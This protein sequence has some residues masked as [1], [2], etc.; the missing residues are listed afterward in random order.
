MRK[1]ILTSAVLLG[2]VVAITACHPVH[3]HHHDGGAS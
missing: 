1:L 3:I 2:G